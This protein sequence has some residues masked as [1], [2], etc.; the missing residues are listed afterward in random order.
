MFKCSKCGKCCINLNLNPIYKDLDRGDGICKY[1]DME[2]RLCTIYN[3]RPIKCNVDLYYELYLKD[4]MDR[5]EYYRL[6][7]LVCRKL[8]EV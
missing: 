5:E 3:K 7:Y 1:F 8:K 6:N 2:K 4:K